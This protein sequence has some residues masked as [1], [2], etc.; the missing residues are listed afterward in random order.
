[1]FF[2]EECRKERNWPES[3]ARSQGRCEVCKENA[4]CYDVKSSLLPKAE[5]FFDGYEAA[6]I[7]DKKINELLEEYPITEKN[8]IE[9]AKFTRTVL[10]SNKIIAEECMKFSPITKGEE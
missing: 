7:I 6:A 9:W 4:V 2:C 8:V 1:M 10:T 5:T 3:M